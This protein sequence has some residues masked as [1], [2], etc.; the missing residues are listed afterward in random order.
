MRLMHID[1]SSFPSAPTGS[2]VHCDI[3]NGLRLWAR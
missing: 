3:L 2:I 1:I